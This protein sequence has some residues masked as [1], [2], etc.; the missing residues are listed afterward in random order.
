[1]N[2]GHTLSAAYPG[3][4]IA[5]FAVTMSIAIAALREHHPYPRF[6]PAN[7]VTTVRALL[8]ATVAGFIG[9]NV[10]PLLAVAV[11][12]FAAVAAV[13]DGLDG[14]LARRTGLA[15][16]FGARFDVEVDALL[17]QVLAVIA[18]QDQ[19]AGT[20]VLASG[21]VRYAFVAAGRIWP[22]MRAPLT[23]TRRARLICVLQV[24]ALIVAI[25][26]SMTPP[27][28]HGIAA[29]GLALLCYSFFADTLRLWRQR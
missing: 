16:A 20:W 21:L 6:G 10:V 18:W 9:E 3:K 27:L 5:V 13:L 28:S 26:P 25:L 17:I 15:S 14:W 24:I 7:V 4:V 23:P 19:K 29:A 1:M 8:V 11:A 2:V 22:W 12:G